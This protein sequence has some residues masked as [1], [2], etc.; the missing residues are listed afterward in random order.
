M[1]SV[2]I[3]VAVIKI[4]RCDMLEML[5]PGARRS[6]PRR[7][8][9]RQANCHRIM[10]MLPD[11]RHARARPVA[12][13]AESA[14]AERPEVLRRLK[15]L[16]GLPRLDSEHDLVR[17]VEQGM[18]ARTIESLCQ[19]GL[20]DDEVYALLLPR[21][22]LAHRRA[23]GESF[24]RD[25]SDRIVRVARIAALGEQVFGEPDRAWRWL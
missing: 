19:H 22:T 18:P 12:A 24:S 21:R 11:R 7:R 1:A 16:L 6:A 8:L 5:H 2:P 25:E 17:L 9:T 4:H 15:E 13:A 23:R 20:T 10:A 14:A 3:A